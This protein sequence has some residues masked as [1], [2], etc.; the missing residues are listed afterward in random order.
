MVLA[1]YLCVNKRKRDDSLVTDTEQSCKLSRLDRD[2]GRYDRVCQKTLSLTHPKYHSGRALNGSL[3]VKAD[4]VVSVRERV[5][6]MEWRERRESQVE[7]GGARTSS[8]EGGV[9]GESGGERNKLE[10]KEIGG[11]RVASGERGGESG[12]R[13]EGGGVSGVQQVDVFGL[14]CRPTTLLSLQPPKFS[15]DKPARPKLHSSA[16]KL[17]LHKRSDCQI[18]AKLHSSARKLKLHKPSNSQILSNIQFWEKW[19]MVK[20]GSNPTPVLTKGQDNQL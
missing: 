15:K 3:Q 9:S 14:K 4:P 11:V 10:R 20:T 1:D 18:S 17:K 13:R 6:Q 7:S 8:V 12:S 16:S 19:G 5:E 2:S